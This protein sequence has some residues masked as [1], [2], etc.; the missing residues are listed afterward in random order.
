MRRMFCAMR[1]SVFRSPRLLLFIAPVSLFLGGCSGKQS[2]GAS[3][4]STV[5]SPQP[6]AAARATDS[7]ITGVNELARYGDLWKHAS[8]MRLRLSARA[9]LELQL[10]EETATQIAQSL[11]DC[12]GKIL[13]VL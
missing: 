11:G 7:N 1:E 12:E 4:Q 10:P 13:C 2:P 8:V 3:T 5:V 9:A 6:S